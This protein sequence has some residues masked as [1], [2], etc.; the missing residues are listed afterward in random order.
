MTVQR[1][2]A[3]VMILGSS[4][5]TAWTSGDITFPAILGMLG[6]LGVQRR[7]TWDIR[8]EKHFITPLLLLLLAVLFALHCRYA[9]VRVDQAAAFAW[10]TIARYF[11]A[12]MILILFLRPH[13]IG[14][15]GLRIADFGLKE[16]SDA[17]PQSAIRNLQSCSTLPP[18]LGLFHLASVLAAG[19]IL[20]LDDRYVAFRLVELASV[21]LVILY[22]AVD[23]RPFRIS[24]F[25]LWI[26]SERR[27][28]HPP[29]E[30]RIW[31]GSWLPLS[32]LLLVA[33]NLG[34]IAGSL[35]YR[36]VEAINFLPAWLSHGNIPVE[37]TT[38]GTAQV[39]FSTSGELSTIL[40]IKEDAD[41]TPVLSI[42]G[43]NPTYLRAKAFETYYQSAWHELTSWEG[44]APE[45]M[46]LGML[47]GRTNLYRLHDADASRE[48]TI[49]HES[50][51]GDVVFTPS[52]TCFVEAPFSFVMRNDDDIVKSQNVRSHQ[53]YRIGYTAALSNRPPTSLQWHHLTEPPRPLDPQVRQIASRLLGHCTTTAQKIDAVTKYFHTN[54]A[55]VLGL[56]VPADQDPLNYFLLHASTGYCE[57]FASG[58][59]ILL[60]LAGVPTRYVTG[61]LVTERGSDKGAWIARNMD[62]HAWAEAWDKEQG[63]WVVVEATTQEGLDDVSLADELAR[64]AGGTRPF[65]TRLVQSLYEYG[66]FG[67]I[68]QFFVSYGLLTGTGLSLV[69][70]GAAGWI[71]VRRHRHPSSAALR[72]PSAEVLAWHRLLAAVDRQARALGYRRRGDETLHA[73]AARLACSEYRLQ[74]GETLLSRAKTDETAQENQTRVN[75]VLRTAGWY[76]RY[77]DL[78][79]RRAADPNAAQTKLASLWAQARSAGVRPGRI[80]RLRQIVQ[81]RL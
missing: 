39:G 52:G 61:F 47:L 7:F 29:S 80:E 77:A 44:I 45:Q 41:T 2:I 54:Y 33:V 58:A 22:A 57:Y 26:G 43:S 60:R 70:L 53:S 65:L 66:L 17:N 74:A 59:A 49:R 79:Y 63:Q 3:V 8:P 78:R 4:V 23:G 40:S 15:F 56:E 18:S 37:S 9:H 27:I 69:F 71:A 81:K 21:I 11:L 20:L 72:L 13:R 34:W 46:P 55:Y 1:M 10:Q 51:L 16:A 19:Q 38:A 5:L 75:A 24:D 36:Q 62:A 28:R 25:G 76:F 73:F 32:L 14:D 68:G 35:L 12:S 64:S 30:I 31:L 67:V 48:M 6:L 50:S 42:T